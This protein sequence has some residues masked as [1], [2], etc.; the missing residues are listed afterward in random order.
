MRRECAIADQT[1]PIP[2]AS[3]F[4]QLHLGDPIKHARVEHRRERATYR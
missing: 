4:S 3:A 2:L 1:D